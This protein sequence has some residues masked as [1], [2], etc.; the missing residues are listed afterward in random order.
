MYFY[1]IKGMIVIG[2]I[3]AHDTEVYTTIKKSVVYIPTSHHQCYSTGRLSHW[4][5]RV[6][7]AGYMGHTSRPMYPGNASH[8]HIQ[9]TKSNYK[10]YIPKMTYNSV[11]SSYCRYYQLLLTSHWCLKDGQWLPAVTVMMELVL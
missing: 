4:C 11:S 10:V 8:D 5:V 6:D 1:I 3:D 7:T 2:D 9:R